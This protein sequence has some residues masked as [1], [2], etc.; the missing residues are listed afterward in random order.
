MPTRRLPLKT[1]I[2]FGAGLLILG[3]ALFLESVGRGGGEF[4][5]FL[6][7]VGAVC[8][9]AS[10]VFAIVRVISKRQEQRNRAAP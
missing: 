4:P 5:L 6:T 1:T 2:A 10:I 8:V 9:V 7:L 3:L